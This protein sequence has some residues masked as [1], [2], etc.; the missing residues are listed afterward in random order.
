M[1][2]HDFDLTPAHIAGLTDRQAVRTLFAQLGYAVERGKETFA[3]AEGMSEK[4]AEA[5][6]HIEL[7]ARDE[8][9]LLDV[10]LMELSSVTVARINDLAAHYR[11]R[12]GD[13]LAVLTTDYQRLD[14]VLFERQIPE[15][16]G[17][18][19]PAVRVIPRRLSVD[20]LHD[21]CN[22][23]VLRVLRRLSW[24][25]TDAL[26]Q[27]DKLRSAF[28]IGEWS[29]EFFDN[30]GLFADYFLKERLPDR[31]EWNAEGLKDA[32]REVGGPILEARER[33]R[34]AD[35]A[36]LRAELREPVLTRLGFDPKPVK[37]TR[38]GLDYALPDPETGERLA[39]CA[40]YQWDRFLDGPDPRDRVTPD[41]NP[42]ATVLTL[43]EQEGNDW[44]LVTNGKHW[45]LYTRK[46]ESRATN[47][48]QVDAEEAA[49]GTEPD[50]F[51][52]LWL[53]FRAEA[54]RRREVTV[55]GETRSVNLLEELLEGS[56][57]YAK[58]VGDRLKGRVFEDI[59]P[60]L[61]E[62]FVADIRAREGPAAELDD[63]RLDLIFQSTLVL[64][65][66]LLFLLYAESRD[67]LPVREVGGYYEKSLT[68]LKREIRD[69]GGTVE[70]QRDENLKAAKYSALPAA[71][72]LP[73][74]DKGAAP[75]LYDRLLEL[76]AVV[77]DGRPALNMPQY[78]G[79]LFCESRPESEAVDGEEV[80]QLAPV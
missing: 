50:A 80:R 58:Q 41:E 70:S 43:L 2:D 19:T 72:G 42:G 79:G 51:R 23:V 11:N 52:Y 68:A 45:R 31:A 60:I 47:F 30:R 14:F 15:R 36:T 74:A 9:E 44:A 20:R 76:F 21:A 48:L 5:V 28:A 49:A 55:E 62:G 26:A 75:G 29:E 32:I 8:H 6:K 37:G 46:T 57:D 4:L 22:R 77:A 59:F 54:F 10:Y 18:P 24:T 56:R 69:A 67:L 53:L 17:G 34:E 7:V 39:V 61:A 33:L 66:R 64:L 73:S 38:G 3:D 25:Q 40:A 1:L 65:Y 78:N 35:E 63:E 27:A 16:S 12:T 13:Y 71:S